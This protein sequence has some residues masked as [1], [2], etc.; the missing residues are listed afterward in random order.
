MTAPTSRQH[1]AKKSFFAT[2]ELDTRL[3]GMIGAFVICCA[4]RVQPPHRRAVPD[5][6]QHLQPDDPDGLGG[7]HGHRHGLRDRHPP[8]RP[9]GRRAAG[10][11][12]GD[13]GDDPDGDLAEWL[14]LGLNHPADRADGH[15]CRAWLAGAI[16]GAFHGWLVGYLT[17]PAFIVTLGGLLVWRN[18]AWH[19]TGGQTIGPLDRDLHALR[20]HQR[21]AGRDRSW[22]FGAVADRPPLLAAWN[23]RRN[24]I[25]HDFPV[26]PIWAEM[27]LG[28]IIGGRD[29]GLRLRS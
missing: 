25:R 9:V 5:A 17:I 16:I 1:P 21:H 4:H 27:A 6:A 7:D 15:H 8:H 2:L 10:D 23:A 3:L 28:A 20:R 12:L 26:K 14:G 19:L 11:L 24:K 13:H 18:V 22:I 29:P